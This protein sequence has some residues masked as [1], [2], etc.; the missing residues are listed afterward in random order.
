MGNSRSHKS[1]RCVT[2]MTRNGMNE[3]TSVFLTTPKTPQEKRRDYLNQSKMNNNK[4][5]CNNISEM[6]KQLKNN[7][8]KLGNIRKIEKSNQNLQNNL[9]KSLVEKSDSEFLKDFHDDYE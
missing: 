8:V 5:N 3:D 7:H 1:T 9:N 6:V 2:P 4:P